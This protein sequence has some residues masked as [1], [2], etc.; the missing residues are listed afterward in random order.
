[1][2]TQPTSMRRR[3]FLE[4]CVTFC[5]GIAGTFLVYSCDSDNSSSPTQPASTPAPQA[6]VTVVVDQA[7]CR[8]CGDCV[9]SCPNNAISLGRTA[10]ID[11]ST[12]DQCLTCVSVCRYN[13]IR[14]T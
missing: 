3:T 11:Q 4:T 5:A 6:N 14:V 1:M 2:N 10:V 12:C 9:G 8:A 13:A 7:R